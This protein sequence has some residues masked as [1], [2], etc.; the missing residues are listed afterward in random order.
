MI[1]LDKNILTIFWK[2]DFNDDTF[3]EFNEDSI[4]KF[5]DKTLNLSS[6]IIKR[7]FV[8]LKI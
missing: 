1:Y 4:Y 2:N 5:I 3:P 6:F 8:K 7:R